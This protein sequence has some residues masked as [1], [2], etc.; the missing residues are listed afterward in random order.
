MVCEVDEVELLELLDDELPLPSRAYNAELDCSLLSMTGL[1]LQTVTAG[2]T[3]LT[4][5]LIDTD[6]VTEYVR[7]DI[8][9]KSVTWQS[10]DVHNYVNYFR[11]QCAIE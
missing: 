9:V 2:K 10:R 7:Y 3:T 4:R 6:T 8:T 5:L 1:L 11:E